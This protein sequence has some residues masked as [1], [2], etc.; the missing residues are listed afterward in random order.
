MEKRLRIEF[1]VGTLV[2]LAGYVWYAGKIDTKIGY[3]EDRLAKLERIA[4]STAS[5]INKMDNRITRVESTAAHVAETLGK[6][7]RTLTEL[8]R[9]TR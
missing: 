9:K 7:D 8:N 5:S 1:M 2:M 6:I 4:E 3:Q